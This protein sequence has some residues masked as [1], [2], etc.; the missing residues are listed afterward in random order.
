MYCVNAS[1]NKSP[2]AQFFPHCQAPKQKNL[3][4]L[5]DFPSFFPNGAPKEGPYFK[6]KR[7]AVMAFK[8]RAFVLTTFQREHTRKHGFRK[9]TSKCL[10][11]VSKSGR[12]ITLF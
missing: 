11:K 10:S 5:K 8:A 12:I 6:T 7:E 2:S 3:N 1:F 4:I 9:R